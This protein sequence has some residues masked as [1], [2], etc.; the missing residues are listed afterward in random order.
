MEEY[1]LQTKGLTKTY[2]RKAVVN[3]VNLQ[4]RRNSV[5]GLLGPN[6]AGKSTTLKL[7]TGILRPTEG[8]ITFDGHPWTRNDLWDISALIENPP[9]YE[10]LTAEE[11][12]L[13]KVKM[14]GLDK[15]RIP[16]VLK[17]VDL[18]DSNR[19]RAK[20]FSLGMKQRLGIALA[21]LNEPKLLILDEPTNGL[22]PIG[23]QELRTLIRSFTEEGIT[24]I[25]SS[26]ILSE[27]EQVADDIGIITD[28][29]LG[30]QGWI[31]KEEN[32]EQLFMETVEKNRREAF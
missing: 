30:Y 5:Y 14:L 13:V 20:E 22:D 8:E 21:L 25:L 23:I 6:G 19:K 24:V 12:L 15:T 29:V 28:G 18:K 27:V 17:T 7:L 16:E 3:H 9:L 31:S 26:H 1:M 2:G 10:N 11:N 4:V 32:L